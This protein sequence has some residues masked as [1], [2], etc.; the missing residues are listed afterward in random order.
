MQMKVQKEGHMSFLGELNCF[1]LTLECRWIKVLWKISILCSNKHGD[2][3]NMKS[4]AYL[5]PV[6]TFFN[7]LNISCIYAMVKW[8]YLSKISE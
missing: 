3:Q 4:F 8:Q 5:E 7:L 1:R 6:L 2:S